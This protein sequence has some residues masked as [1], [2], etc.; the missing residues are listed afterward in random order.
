MNCECV[1]IYPA[2]RNNIEKLRELS[3]ILRA[4][5]DQIEL[6]PVA[7]SR[8]TTETKAYNTYDEAFGWRPKGRKTTLHPDDLAL[9]VAGKYHYMSK[10]MLRYYLTPEDRKTLSDYKIIFPSSDDCFFE[11]IEI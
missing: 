9:F 7:I 5:S 4:I 2:D 6:D 3:R 11:D 1:I 8:I 10:A